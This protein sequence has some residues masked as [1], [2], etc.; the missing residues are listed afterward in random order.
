MSDPYHA[1]AGQ[2]GTIEAINL[3]TGY[4]VVH[5]DCDG[6]SQI[7][8]AHRSYREEELTVFVE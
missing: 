8:V 3:L 4:S 2:Q 7:H 6:V 1:R 5:W